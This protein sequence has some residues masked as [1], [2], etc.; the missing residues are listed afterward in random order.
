MQR[1]SRRLSPSQQRSRLSAPVKLVFVPFRRV[2]QQRL[3]RHGL[4]LLPMRLHN[5]ALSLWIR[6]TKLPLPGHPPQQINKT[7]SAPT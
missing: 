7:T 2:L 6:F 4:E 1:K 3:M 5:R